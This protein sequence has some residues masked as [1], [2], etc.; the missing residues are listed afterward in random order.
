MNNEEFELRE[1]L[2]RQ[3]EINDQLQKRIKKYE[4]AIVEFTNDMALMSLTV[5]MEPK[6]KEVAEPLSKILEIGNEITNRKKRSQVRIS[7]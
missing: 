2:S 5:S 1:E 6:L 3:R 4:N 7:N